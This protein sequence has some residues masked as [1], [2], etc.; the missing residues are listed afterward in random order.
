MVKEA[1]F[2]I[3]APYIEKAKFLD[4]FAGVGAVGLE[5][6][7]RGASSVTF[8]DA[9]PY[10]IRLIRENCQCVDPELPVTIMK[11]EVSTAI[12]KLTKNGEV[13]DL[14]YIDPPYDLSNQYIASILRAIFEGHLLAEDGWLFL[15]NASTQPILIYGLTLKRRRKLGGTFLSEYFLNN[16]TESSPEEFS[17]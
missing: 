12:Q 15:E 11:Q 7:S 2:N 13:F 16:P 8:V 17:I 6:L 1:V 3:C 4:L 14:I 9:S 10:A 5:A